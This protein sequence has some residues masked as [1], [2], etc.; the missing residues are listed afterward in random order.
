[1]GYALTELGPQRCRQIAEE[2]FRVEKAYRQKLHGFCPIHGDQSSASFVYHFH[3]DWFKCRSCSEGGDLVK[4]WCQLNGKEFLD[5]KREFVGD[6]YDKF[7]VQKHTGVEILRSVSKVEP[8]ET[9]VAEKDL[10]ALPSLPSDRIAELKQLRGWSEEVIEAL[11]LRQFTDFKG[12]HR[13]AMPIRDDEGRLCNIRLYQPGAANYKVISW[14]DQSCK[15]CG[16]R[17]KSVNKQKLCQKC[18][19]LPNDY[20]RSRL[21][22]PPSQWKRDE[23]LWLCEGEPD[24]VCALSHGLNA[25]TQTAGCGT[26]PDAFSQAMTGRD[27]VICYDAD[28]AGFKGAMKAA[29]TIAEHAQSV[30]VIRW[31]EEMGR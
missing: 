30:R 22:P 2:L 25:C 8:A 14:Y 13:I 12:N 1:M 11:D 5:F 29:R 31:P 4:L 20:G 10:V 6:I 16:G 19:A 7:Q 28:Q 15:A 26:W 9:F 18:E 24:L 27:M 3:E 21:Y 23:L 17:W